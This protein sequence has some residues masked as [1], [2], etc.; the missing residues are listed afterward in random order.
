MPSRLRVLVVSSDP[1]N[2]RNLGSIL[3]ECGL[4]PVL[5]STLEEAQSLLAKPGVLLA[6]CDAELGDGTFRELLSLTETAKI[7]VVVASR[8]YK[9]LQYLEAMRLGAFDFIAPPYRRSELAHILASA[10]HRPNAA[11]AGGSGGFSAAT[12]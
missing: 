4:D 10:L 1:D 2:G 12:R 11:A 6:F 9:T 8:V 5:T 7:P 3:S